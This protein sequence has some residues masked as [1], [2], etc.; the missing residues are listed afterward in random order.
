LR[1]FKFFGEWYENS[2]ILSALDNTNDDNVT[3]R[4]AL[5]GQASVYSIP[6]VG[7]ATGQF[8]VVTGALTSGN[9][10]SASGTAGKLADSGLVAANVLSGSIAT[11]DTNANLVSFDV[12]CGQATLAAAGSVVLINSS[13]AKQYKLRALWINSGGTNFSGGGGDRLGQVTDGT[14]V[15]SVVPAAD[16]QTLVNAGWGMST[17]LPFPASAAI[18]TST[19]AGADLVFKYSGGAADYTAGSIVV[20]GIAERV[21]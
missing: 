4:N 3:I 7:A 16:M 17:P 6:D 14:T 13:G 19:A 5:H 1:R 15:Y 12:A 20:S 18:D 9:L 21:A 11:P 10:M 2:A 8:N